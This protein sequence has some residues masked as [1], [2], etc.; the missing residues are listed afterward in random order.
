MAW[1]EVANHDY[2]TL[3][4]QLK[5]NPTA[6]SHLI[7]QPKDLEYK[8]KPSDANQCKF[9][10]PFPYFTDALV[11]LAASKLVCLSQTNSIQSHNDAFCALMWEKL[12][13]LHSI[14]QRSFERIKPL[15]KIKHPLSAHEKQFEHNIK[16]IL[17]EAC[18]ENKIDLQLLTEINNALFHLENK[19]D[20]PL[21]FNRSLHLSHN[22]MNLL[23]TLY[24]LLYNIRTLVAMDYNAHI[25]EMSL[26]G[27]KMDPV[28]DYL[29]Q[30]HYNVNDAI[31]YY[32][33]QSLIHHN[34]HPD[35]KFAE[36]MEQAFRNLTHNGYYLV[37]TL[38]PEIFELKPFSQIEESVN[39]FQ[40]DWLLGTAGGLLY[41]LREEI[42]GLKEGYDKLFWTDLNE[43]SLEP[44]AVLE[45][46][47]SIGPE[48]MKLISE[49]A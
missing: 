48:Q 44:H 10:A 31:L 33:W 18:A 7:I 39:R 21:L 5:I 2:N 35:S 20:E 6:S 16:T 19:L 37:K 11:G 1:N 46:Q 34:P 41:R 47:C 26:E 32:H 4:I 30:T 27:I 12:E 17:K 29:Q 24:S 28:G 22:S 25:K 15:V 49:A 8:I 45:S 43:K 13:P 36:S 23:H 9:R 40:V 14:F 38:P 3:C 42:Y